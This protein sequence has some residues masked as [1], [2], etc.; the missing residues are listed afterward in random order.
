MFDE[1]IEQL[2]AEYLDQY[3]AIDEERPELTRFMGTVGQVRAVNFNSQALV[4][5]DADSNRGRHDIGLDYLKVVDKPEPPPA[6]PKAKPAVKKAA[7]AAS[8]P[9]GKDPVS[10]ESG[11]NKPDAKLS[12]LEVA[13]MKKAEVDA[14]DDRKSND[15]P[16]G[17]DQ[18]TGA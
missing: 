5:F 3:V 2:K 15:A 18:K 17:A 13:R 14:T 10:A 1:H 6:K 7:D 9:S 16:T 8:K 4:E 12:A 11:K